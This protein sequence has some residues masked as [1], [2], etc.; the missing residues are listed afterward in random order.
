M[1]FSSLFSRGLSGPEPAIGSVFGSAL[2]TERR[3]APSG[4]SGAPAIQPGDR[5]NGTITSAQDVDSIAIHLE[6]GQE[7]TFF[8]TARSARTGL[9]DPQLTLRDGQGRELAFSEDVNAA[10]DNFFPA[11]RFTAQETGV[12][13]LQVGGWEDTTG[14]YT[15]HANLSTFTIP[16]VVT[17]LTEFAWGEATPLRHAERARGEVTVN[18]ASLSAEAQK[19]ALWAL[20]AWGQVTGHVFRQVTHLNAEILFRDDLEGVFGGADQF[21]IRTGE[22]LTSIV[23]VEASWLE[24]HGTTIDSFGFETYVHEVGHAL[25]LGHP[26]GY[27]GFARFAEDHLFRND[28]VRTTVMS[29]FTPWEGEAESDLR[30][31]Y[32]EASPGTV[33]TPMIA[34]VAALQSLYGQA[35]IRAGNTVYGANSN[36]G[37]WLEVLSGI[38]FDGEAGPDGFYAGG[39]VLMT[40]ADTGGTDLFDFSTIAADQV[41]DLRAGGVSSVAGH[42][43]N[44]VLALGAVIEQARGGSGDDLIF[45]NAAA[46]RLEAGAGNDSLWGD[47]G[48]DRL[49]G[50]VGDDLLDGGAGR[51]SLRGDAGQDRL[52]GGADADLLEGGPGDDWLSGGAANDTLL[53]GDGQDTLAGGAGRDSLTGGLGADVFVFLSPTDSGGASSARDRITDFQRG[54]DLIDL[55]AIDANRRLAGDQDFT[56]RGTAAFTGQAGELRWQAQDRSSVLVSADLDGDRRADMT[57]VV[58]GT[59]VL[60]AADFILI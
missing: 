17:M 32:A 16:Q 27:D 35:P 10:D 26:G 38:L 19:L 37:G 60:D 47:A 43:G 25:G 51:D 9:Y 11:I 12:H 20:E 2:V 18:I 4:L 59:T 31:P 3:D 28:H 22:I 30:N 29:Y 52:D 56:L 54:Q 15:L 6:A 58:A 41:I 57:F 5:F 40:I 55:S 49:W 1:A 53:G 44:L 33:I 21:V 34:D 13:Y 50:G 36:V 39:N 8:V 24:T 7:Y 42:D 45:G 48:A 23:N 14:T 46:N